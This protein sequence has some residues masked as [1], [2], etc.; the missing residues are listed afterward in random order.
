MAVM[1]VAG[2]AAAYLALGRPWNFGS[3]ADWLVGSATLL[4]VWVALHT[5]R[6][7][8]DLALAVARE[9]REERAKTQRESEERHA[10]AMIFVAEYGRVSLELLS[11][12]TAKAGS[13]KG[14]ERPI[15]TM[16]IC[17]ITTRSLQNFISSYVH[18]NHVL[19]A[20]LEVEA[21]WG[22]AVNCADLRIALHDDAAE[23]SWENAI[24]QLDHACGQ[25]AKRCVEAGV[26]PALSDSIHVQRRLGA[27]M[28]Q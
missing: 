9:E 4:A 21:R 23:A 24:G 25:L 27:A 13:L 8:G 6:R 12:T 14:L 28:Q 22:V 1:S 10:K 5:A 17:K 19:H 20:L 18:T 3:V 26:R 11:D 7:Q 2:V 15:S 16:E